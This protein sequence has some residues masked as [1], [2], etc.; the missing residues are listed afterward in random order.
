[1]K[2]CGVGTHKG[3]GS[4][5][6]QA[7]GRV[8]GRRAAHD[9]AGAPLGRNCKISAQPSPARPCPPLR[10]HLAITGAHKEHHR[11]VES[12][13]TGGLPRGAALLQKVLRHPLRQRLQN[14]E[15]R[16]SG[17]AWQGQV[18]SAACASVQV[19]WRGVRMQQSFRQ[20]VRVQP[21]QATEHRTAVH[22]QP[23]ES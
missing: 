10:T 16:C 14:G 19:D 2:C 8:T 22:A 5:G 7:G 21:Q 6:G 23:V 3:V 9:H 11:A 1:M 18:S 20:H 4:A 17:G 15:S 12:G 13:L